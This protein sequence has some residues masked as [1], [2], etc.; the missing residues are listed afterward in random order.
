MRRFRVFIPYHFYVEKNNKNSAE[1][2]SIDRIASVARTKGS[3]F[4]AQL[5]SFYYFLIQ[6]SQ[7]PESISLQ[8]RFQL[9]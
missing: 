6:S 5:Q 2:K 4:Y 1:Q 3:A 8:M 9:S 7:E